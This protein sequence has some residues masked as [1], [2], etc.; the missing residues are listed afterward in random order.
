MDQGYGTPAFMQP[1]ADRDPT[2]LPPTLTIRPNSVTPRKSKL[3]GFG[4]G[5]M[6]FKDKITGKWMEDSGG[7]HTIS[8]CRKEMNQKK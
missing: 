7:E 5:M 2:I 3:C 8:R 6:V 4:C 1:D